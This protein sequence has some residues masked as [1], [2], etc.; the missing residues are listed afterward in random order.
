M[1]HIFGAMDRGGAELRTLGLV[2]LVPGVDHSYV[3]LSGRRGELA[4]GI[5]AGGGRVIPCRLSLTFP[6]R[7][8][9][10]LRRLRP[11][12]VQS[13]VATFSGAIVALAWLAGVPRRVAHFRSDGDQYGNSGRRR[14]QRRM[15]R[16]LIAWFAT[17]VIGG[18]PAALAFG[19]PNRRPSSRARV[20]PDGVAVGRRPEETDL[21]RSPA[22]L[23]HVART[24]ESKRR[25]R[26]V[27]I[28][29]ACLADGLDVEL[30]LVGTMTV[31]ENAELAGLCA[32]LDL[33][34]HVHFAG[35]VDD[36]SPGLSDASALLVTS[37]REGLPGVVLEALAQGCP[38]VSTNLP[39]VAY[40]SEFC[41]GITTVGADA[42]DQEWVQAIRSALSG[43]AG[44]R[45][46]IWESLSRSPFNV[47]SA[48]QEMGTLW[49]PLS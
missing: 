46:E 6:I 7:F 47:S 39:G 14:L 25:A 15:M 8:F 4:D 21:P 18:A 17:D 42:S 10:L 12:L 30:D 24:L 5:E 41:T 22:A 26:A 37:T 20:I 48:A 44:S 27:E 1:V 19:R 34:Q 13:N 2:A 23:V 45:L 3:T 40:I 35:P 38:V 9:L 33:S 11:D 32:T 29:A 43:V 49:Q 28:L 31:E 16:R 36:V